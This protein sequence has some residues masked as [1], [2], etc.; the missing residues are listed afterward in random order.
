[1]LGSPSAFTSHSVESLPGRQF[2]AMMEF[3]GLHQILEDEQKKSVE[4]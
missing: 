2:S 1:M 3:L 4:T